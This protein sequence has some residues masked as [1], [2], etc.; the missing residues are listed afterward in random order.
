MMLSQLAR[1]LTPYEAGEQPRGDLIKLNTNESAYPP[2]PKVRDALVSVVSDALGVLRLY[3]DPNAKELCAALGKKHG[4]NP[5]NIIITNGSDESLA[6]AYAA[7]LAGNEYAT[8][9]IGY[10]FYKSYAKL[11]GAAT[12]FTRMNGDMTVDVDA[13]VGANLPIVVANPN[14]PTTLALSRETI[15]GVADILNERGQVMIVD[16]AYGEFA[17]ESVITDTQTR[18]NLLVIRTFS[19]AYALAGMRVGYA[20][21]SPQLIN[22]MRIVRDSFNSYPIDRLAQI[23]A[24]AAVEDDEHLRGCVSKTL[25]TGSR[26]IRE[27]RGM[28][29]IAAES[30][31]N[32]VFARHPK[33]SGKDLFEHLR[34]KNIIVRRFGSAGIDDYVRITIGTDEQMDIVARTLRDYIRGN[35]GNDI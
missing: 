9:E 5:D 20:V 32:F 1:S 16:E 22:G 35:A 34:S 8:P 29:F 6:F 24:L 26:F 28:G 12:R 23:A 21:G 7:F 4:V 19:K 3:P 2:S 31:T 11:F 27:L 10:S 30:K 14:A 33:H 17:N 13:L 15:L 25:A 18:E